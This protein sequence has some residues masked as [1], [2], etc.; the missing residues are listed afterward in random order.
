[1]QPDTHPEV[2]WSV[3]VFSVRLC[4]SRHDSGYSHVN[5]RGRAELCGEYTM[6]PEH[7]FV[8]APDVLQH[9]AE[10]HALTLKPV[11]N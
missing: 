2:M 4:A 6:K 10:E 11:L 7:S 8:S 9:G 3:C 1:M 5:H